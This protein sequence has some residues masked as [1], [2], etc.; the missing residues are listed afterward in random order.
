MTRLEFSRIRTRWR[1]PG[2]LCA[3]T[4]RGWTAIRQSG[5][6]RAPS[7]IGRAGFR[8]KRSIKDWGLPL[9]WQLQHDF[10]LVSSRFTRPWARMYRSGGLLFNRY[11]GTIC[12]RW[13]NAIIVLFCFGFYIKLSL[14]REIVLKDRVAMCKFICGIYNYLKKLYFSKLFSYRGRFVV[15]KKRI[16]IL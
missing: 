15:T 12:F 5:R 11:D 16:K 8:R 6:R 2:V 4:E 3:R 9:F 1:I 14:W 7:R 13:W 10:G